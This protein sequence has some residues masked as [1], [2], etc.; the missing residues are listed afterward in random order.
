MS[1]P[2]DFN[3]HGLAGVR[4]LDAAGR[5]IR[6]VSRQLGPIRG[7]FT[8]D[9]DIVIRFV[10][11]LE[12]SST[13]RLLGLDDAAFTDDAF[14][15]LRSRHKSKA[16]VKIPIHQI[17]EGCEFVCE[18]G[19]AMVPLLIPIL[20]LTVLSK[21]ALPLHAAAW[22]HGGRGTVATGW[23]KGG[24]TETLLAYMSRGASYVG[25]EW[26]YL[27]PSGKKMYGI[28]EPIRVWSWHL[29]H[30]PHFREL[31]A[32]KDRAR[33]GTLRSVVKGLERVTGGSARHGSALTRTI[34][35]ITPLLKKQLCVDIEPHVLFGSEACVMEGSPDRFLFVASHESEE[36]SLRRVD[37]QEVARRMVFS[38][39]EEQM[40]FMSYYW[41][42]RFAF[43]DAAS[44]LVETS[45][46][47]QQAALE[48][49]LAGKEAF[50]MVHPYPVSIPS[51]FDV[52][53][54]GRG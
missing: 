44:E 39:Q 12:N 4:L 23:S 36:V 25:D 19:L 46:E 16:R 13:V 14:L 41:K 22:I 38:L 51:L 10:D 43:P 33:I 40:N 54:N 8:G 35:R 34:N 52:V 17:G 37:P 9:P 21:G 24:K 49:I 15:V 48:R 50:E 1:A 32:S 53:E 31:V 28:P 3:L 11:R 30:L 42:F 2:V 45:R 7:D 5:E 26:V 47:R 18:R 27:D 20:N 6:A 29:E